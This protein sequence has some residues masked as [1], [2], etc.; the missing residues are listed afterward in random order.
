VLKWL[1]NRGALPRE[2]QAYVRIITGRP[3]E[4]W[5]KNAAREE[6]IKIAGQLPC[7]DMPAFA[8]LKA[9][10]AAEQSEPAKDEA[11]NSRFRRVREWV[12]QA[13]PRFWRVVKLPTGKQAASE[14][15]SKPATA[16]V[17]IA[18]LRSKLVKTKGDAAKPESKSTKGT[19]NAEARSNPAKARVAAALQKLA[20]R[21]AN[22]SRSRNWSTAGKKKALPVASVK[23]GRSA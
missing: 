7:R 20:S 4:D 1:A 2:T 23:S 10:G 21:E 19:G 5:R 17:N 12:T 8:E 3:A 14:Q 15:R 18:M 6:A 13:K 11:G 16:K 22:P 9:A